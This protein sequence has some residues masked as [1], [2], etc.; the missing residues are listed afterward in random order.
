MI[1]VSKQDWIVDVDCFKCGIVF[2]VSNKLNDNWKRD[3]T[4]FYCPN[5]HG[6]SYSKSTADILQEKL[7]GKERRVTYL[8]SE[9]VRLERE[10]NK[11]KKPARKRK[12]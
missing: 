5:G 4:T 12:S 7:D 11:L 8:E 3:K 2:W 10:N 1:N 6:Q 9:N